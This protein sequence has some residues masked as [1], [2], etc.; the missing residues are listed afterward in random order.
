VTVFTFEAVNSSNAITADCVGAAVGAGVARDL[1]G[2]ITF[3]TRINYA[4]ATAFALTSRAA[5]I[6]SYHV[7]VVAL[8]AIIPLISQDPVAA[9]SDAASVC[10]TITT[11][12]VPVV[13]KFDANPDHAI[14][15]ARDLTTVQAG[16]GIYIVAVIASLNTRLDQAVAARGASAGVAA[17]VEVVAI[18]VIASLDALMHD[19]IAADIDLTPPRAAVAVHEVAVIANLKALFAGQQVATP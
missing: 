5:T 18:A 6:T 4:I 1:I 19:P 3:F 17:T 12:I 9:R 2:V 13:T 8:F 10:T 7:S 16:I 14:T 15:A 11:L